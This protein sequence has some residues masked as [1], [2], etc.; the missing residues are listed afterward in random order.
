MFEN[1]N[2][3]P[4]VLAR[5]L[6]ERVQRNPPAKG[7]VL[8]ETGYGPSGLPHIGTF[9][10]VLRTTMV[11]YAFMQMSSVP[12]RLYC[13]S[14]D[15][16]GLR[17]VPTNVPN[18]EMLR[19]YID[20]PL[21]KVPDPFGEYDSFGAHNNARLQAFLNSFGFEYE[22]K[23]STACYASG[24]FDDTL[25]LIC[26]KYE[27]IMDVMLA[28]LRDERRQTYS[29]FL[30]ICPHTG[31]VLQVRMESVDAKNHTVTYKDPKTQDMITLPVTGGHCKLQWKID[32]PMRWCAFDVDFEMCGKDLIDSVRIGSEIA[33][34]LGQNVP[35]NDFTELF[36][37][38]NGQKI[39][40]S[41]GN[42]ITIEGWLDFAPKESLAYYMFQ[43]P[44]RAK[45]LYF[46]VIPKACD[47][48]IDCLARYHEEDEVKRL[49]N[50]VWHVHSGNPPRYETTQITFSILLNLASICNAETKE[51]LWAFVNRY[52]VDAIP[53]TMPFLDNMIDCALKYYKEFIIKKFR[54]PTEQER[55]ALLDLAMELHKFPAHTSAADIQYCVFEV[56]KKHGFTDLKLW[57]QALYQVLLGQ[58]TGPRMGTFISIYGLQ[59]TQQLIAMKTSDH[60]NSN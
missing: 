2:T 46:D 56:G 18:Q 53:E 38:E 1:N 40:K 54:A 9:G 45:R 21:T 15:M 31:K 26:E 50:P 36:L 17:K 35:V 10:E 14:D 41:K 58:D 13:V 16:D 48:Y 24:V 25:K 5:Q 37:D 57:F 7:F 60:S 39:S 49:A 52:D 6:V 55:T 12:T 22:F 3:W 32:W 51:I 20:M 30:P 43:N 42:G 29:P 11:R 33:K 34:I 27:P 47:E 59:E 23:S 8:F 19:Q 44:K 4:V 28:N